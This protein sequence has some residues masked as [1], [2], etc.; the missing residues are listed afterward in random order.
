MDTQRKRWEI[1]YEGLA[2]KM[3]KTGRSNSAVWTSSL[4]TQDSDS[5]DEIQRQS[6]GWFSL[7]GRGR[8]FVLYPALQLIGWGPPTFWRM[9]C[10]TL[11]TKMLISPI[12]CS[13]KP[14][15]NNVWSN[16]WAPW[17]PVKLAHTTNH[18]P[19]YMNWWNKYKGRFKVTRI[20]HWVS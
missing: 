1:Y 4:E 18:P 20:R 11:W 15:Q 10:F 16:I 2:H 9:I 6:P 8:V 13:Q 3:M 5:A 7:T 14:S 19:K 17:S 12:I